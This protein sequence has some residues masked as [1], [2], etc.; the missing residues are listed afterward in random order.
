MDG[1]GMENQAHSPRGLGRVP[2]G[3]LFSSFL[4]CGGAPV[5]LT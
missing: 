3:D 1:V 2:M 5:C 4:L